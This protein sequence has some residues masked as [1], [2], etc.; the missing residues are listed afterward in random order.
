MILIDLKRIELA[1]Y[2][3]LPHLKERILTEPHEAKSALKWAVHEMEDRYRTFAAATARNIR[4]YNETR[5]PARP[6]CRTS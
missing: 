5:D 3:G 1:S 6:R 4:S 2:N